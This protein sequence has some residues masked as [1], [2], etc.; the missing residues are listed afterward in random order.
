MN[1]RA[2]SFLFVCLC[3]CVM[4]HFP[5]FGH[6]PTFKECNSHWKHRCP[7]FKRQAVKGNMLTT[8]VN[9]QAC[10]LSYTFPLY[11][12]SYFYMFFFNLL[13]GISTIFLNRN[14]KPSQYHHDRKNKKTAN[15]NHIMLNSSYLLALSAN[16]HANL[17]KCKRFQFETSTHICNKACWN[18][19]VALKYFP[20]GFCGVQR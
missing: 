1:R 13:A 8:K 14:M 17:W 4:K 10:L 11:A 18:I 9:K 12:Y 15:H 19:C 6:M 7:N 3:V 5:P 2:C 16:L 20:I